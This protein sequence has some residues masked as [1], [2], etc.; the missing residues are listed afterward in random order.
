M[1]TFNYNCNI[2]Q[3]D[4]HDIN[5]YSYFVYRCIV[6]QY[7]FPSVYCNGCL[8]LVLNLGRPKLKSVPYFFWWSP[9]EAVLYLQLDI[10]PQLTE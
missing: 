6:V 2:Y 10:C 7:C 1:K 9:R 8:Y 4:I 3:N 5:I